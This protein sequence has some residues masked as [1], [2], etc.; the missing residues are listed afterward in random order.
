LKDLQLQRRVQQRWRA[1][2]TQDWPPHCI[3]ALAAHLLLLCLHLRLCLLLLLHL[4]L[5]LCLQLLLLLRLQLLLLCLMLLHLLLH[6]PRIQ[7]VR[8]R[9]RA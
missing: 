5:L 8:N 1:A 4:G 9:T 2:C 7:Q 3:D 6:Q